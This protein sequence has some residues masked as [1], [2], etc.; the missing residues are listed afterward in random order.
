MRSIRL[1]T[2]KRIGQAYNVYAVFIGMTSYEAMGGKFRQSRITRIYCLL[3]NAICLTLLP[4]AFW[5]SAKLLSAADWM[6]SYMRVTPYIMFTTNYAA[7]AYTLISRCYRDA[8]LMDLQRIVLQVNREMLRTGKKMNSLLRR[9]FFLKTLTLTYSCLSYILAVFIYQWR[10]Q[11]WSNFCNGLLVNISLTILVVTTFFY[12]IS[13][14]HVA[15]GYDFVNQ[16]LKEVVASQSMDSKRKSKELRSLWALHRNLSYTARRINKHYG[17]QMLALRFD[18]FIYSIINGC[19]G[20][21]YSTTDQEPS[22]E[23]V[24]GS[25]I[26]WARSFD[27]FLND[28]ICDLVSEYQIQP[29]FFAPESSMSNELSSYLIYESS[30]RLDL[31]VCGL[32]PVNKRKWLQMVGSIIVHSSMLFQFHLVMRGGL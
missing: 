17:P 18:Y 7:I 3:I 24:F 20:T 31:L 25:L 1:P 8:M 2:M 30:T 11:N 28:Y 19:I 27:F 13:L 29:K 26:Y 22:F 15:K 5:K 4:R 16:Q 21:I 6:P 32:Y 10:A 23:K 12:F 9:M 14:W